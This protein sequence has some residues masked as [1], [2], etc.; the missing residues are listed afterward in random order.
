MLFRSLSFCLIFYGVIAA[1]GGFAVA[2]EMF[3]FRREVSEKWAETLL[4]LNPVVFVGGGSVLRM[5]S[6][7]LARVIS[8]FCNYLLNRRFVFETSKKERNLL[9]YAICAV[10]VLLLNWLFLELFTLLGV[11][12]WLANILSQLICYPVSFGLQRTIVFR[13]KEP[14]KR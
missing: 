3:S 11:P 1:F 7:A 6:L 10:T 13:T 9:K 14:A 5:V 8:G 2:K 12:A 4:A